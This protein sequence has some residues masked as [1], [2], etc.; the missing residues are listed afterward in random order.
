[1]EFL[2]RT[3][4]EIDLDRIEHNYRQLADR[5]GGDCRVMCVIKANAYGH[6]AVETARLL[7]AAGC[8]WFAVS[9][10]EEAQQLRRGGI[11]ARILILGATPAEYAAA[12]AEGEITQ[13]LYDPDYARELSAAASAA[14]VRV[15]VH[16]KLDTGM[17]RIGFDAETQVEEAAA[18]CCLPGLDAEGV[19]THFATADGDGDPDGSFTRL[20]FDRFVAAVQA[21]EAKGVTFRLR[22]CSNSAAAVTRPDFRLDMVR[23]GIILY[24]LAPSAAV[25]AEG[26][27]PAMSMKARVSM[28]KEVAAG[29]GISYGLTYR[30]ERP[31][32]VATLPV[33]YADGYLRAYGK[34]CV[35]LKGEC[36][37]ILGRVCMDQMIVDVTGL[38][39]R[40]GDTATLFGEDA[41]VLLPVEALSKLAD[42]IN[43]ETVCAIGRRV[44]RVYLRG[45]QAVGVSGL[46]DE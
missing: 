6:G 32:K 16:L 29:E 43:Y 40:E 21:L 26:F 46:L 22:H 38:D 30:T 45:G 15:C 31:M 35:L 34:G 8:G 36:A 41:G 12:L 20:Q 10:I 42:T 7:E 37:P 33:G 1:M 19:F 44:P 18:A 9:N 23:E 4:V 28:V 3:W 25:G 39:V 24:G 14:G 11:G 5:V 17:R 13:A 2:H 27:L